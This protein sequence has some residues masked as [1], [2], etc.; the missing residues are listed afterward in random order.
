MGNISIKENTHTKQVLYDDY[1]FYCNFPVSLFIVST[2][3]SLFST[4]FQ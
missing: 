4:G 1:Q 3:F 2:G